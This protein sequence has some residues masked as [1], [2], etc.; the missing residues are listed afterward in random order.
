MRRIVATLMALIAVLGFGAAS[1][2]WNGPQ[3]GETVNWSAT[4]E[5]AGNGQQNNEPDCVNW[6]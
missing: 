4:I 5:A 6:N 1:V 2:N 3:Q